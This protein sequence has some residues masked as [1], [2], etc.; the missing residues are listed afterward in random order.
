MSTRAAPSRQLPEPP[1]NALEDVDA[2]A[3]LLV[4]LLK[5]AT[6]VSEPMR[7]H[8]AEPLD[9]APTDLRIILA[10]GGEG[11]MAG[12]ELSEIMGVQPMNVSRALVAL[13]QKGLVEPSLDPA[14]RRRKPFRLSAAGHDLFT[15]SVPA[16]AG[17]SRTLFADFSQRDR[18]AFRRAAARLLARMIE[19]TDTP[20][21]PST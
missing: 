14:N 6:F 21:Q 15:R 9:L 3:A 12:H 10:L 8:V 7:R 20:R 19:Q 5:L 16:M 2:D 4:D 1:R 17:V 13:H 18:T 11:E